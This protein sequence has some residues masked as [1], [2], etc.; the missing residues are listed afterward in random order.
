MLSRQVSGS[1]RPKYTSVIRGEKFVFILQMIG[2][3]P[4][5]LFALQ[6]AGAVCNINDIYR[7]TIFS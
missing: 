1:G 7:G 6:I 4:T 3:Q 5:D 2:G